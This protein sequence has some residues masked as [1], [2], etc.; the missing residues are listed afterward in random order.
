MVVNTNDTNILWHQCFG[1]TNFG[2]LRYMS[3]LRMSDGLPLIQPSGVYEGC[4]LREHHHESFSKS[5]AGQAS[6]PFELIHCYIY[7][8]ITTTI[9]RAKYIP[10][11]LHDDFFR[12]ISIY[13]LFNPRMKPLRSPRN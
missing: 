2:T 1:H 13:I 9:G 10:T 11:D 4:M 8:P 3:C 5:L 6:C 12:F 7:G